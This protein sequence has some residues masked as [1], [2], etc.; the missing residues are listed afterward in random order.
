VVGTIPILKGGKLLLVSASR[1]AEWI[2]PKGEWESD[3]S[4]EESAICLCH[5][6][7]VV[8]SRVLVRV[9]N[10]GVLF[11]EGPYVL[12]TFQ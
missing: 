6:V 7:I 12:V 4:M 3:Y 11:V 10:I 2:L 8:L 1:K 5:R 9:G